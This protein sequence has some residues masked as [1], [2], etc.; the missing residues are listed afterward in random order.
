MGSIPVG[1]TTNHRPAG[2]QRGIFLH[3]SHLSLSSQISGLD[4]IL[5]LRADRTHRR[6]VFVPGSFS[7]CPET[8]RT[9]YLLVYKSNNK[10]FTAN[11]NAIFDRKNSTFQQASLLE[12][13]PRRRDKSAARNRP[14]QAGSAPGSESKPEGAQM[15]RF[16]RSAARAPD[17]VSPARRNPDEDPGRE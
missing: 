4:I 17:S 3:S 14:K 1:T 6:S 10:F 7:L 16:R 11:K 5:S 12:G 13:F 15:R 8:K 2:F 9:P